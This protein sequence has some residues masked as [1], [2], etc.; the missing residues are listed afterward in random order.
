[1]LKEICTPRFVNISVYLT[2]LKLIRHW[3]IETNSLLI[4]EF[5]FILNIDWMER[6]WT[7]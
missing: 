2:D 5:I 6:K 7:N 1:M 4:G 3:S